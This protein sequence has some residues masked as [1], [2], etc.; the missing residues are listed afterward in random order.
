MPGLLVKAPR[1][2]G[3]KEGGGKTENLEPSFLVKK[4]VA[5]FLS[6]S[7]SEKKKTRLCT[8]L[9]AT[10]QNIWRL[11][12]ILHRFTHKSFIKTGAGQQ[13]AFKQKAISRWWFGETRCWQQMWSSRVR[14]IQRLSNT[15][16]D[17]P[18]SDVSSP[19]GVCVSV[20]VVVHVW[21]YVWQC[22]HLSGC[23]T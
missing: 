12:K 21:F 23:I 19:R 22:M 2:W 17:V 14:H 18:R 3:H 5:D 1:G 10:A 8:L 15:S 4:A 9:V 6:V 20:G 13:Q 16:P 7:Y 11:L